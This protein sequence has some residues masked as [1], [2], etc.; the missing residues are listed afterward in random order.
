MKVL[1]IILVK[2]FSLLASLSLGFVFLVYLF[3]F[4]DLSSVDWERANGV[5]E[6]TEIIESKRTKGTSWCPRVRYSYQIGGVSY[7]NDSIHFNR[8]CSL[9]KLSASS[10]VRPYKKGSDVTVYYIAG[11]PDKSALKAGLH[12][13][14]YLSVAAPFLGLIGPLFLLFAKVPKTHNKS[15]KKDALKR[16]SS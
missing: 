9:S 6:M 15:S 3:K 1:T 13:T 11:S 14:D 8:S 12:W 10:E 7:E 16:A 5:V 4:I 2:V